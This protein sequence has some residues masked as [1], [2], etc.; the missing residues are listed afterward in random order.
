M[1][2][3]HKNWSRHC[4]G[5]V[6][7]RDNSRTI[8]KSRP[9]RFHP[10]RKLLEFTCFQEYHFESWDW[11]R[12]FLLPNTCTMKRRKSE[13]IFIF[14]WCVQVNSTIASMSFG[15]TV[16]LR[17][18]SASQ[19]WRYRDANYTYR[20]WSMVACDDSLTF[21]IWLARRVPLPTHCHH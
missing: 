13:Y 15:T 10:L 11:T 12:S 6:M 5:R 21:R 7:V 20:W 8:S 2:T 4:E 3:H 19:L 9:T 16:K 17:S 18:I 14:S 1:H